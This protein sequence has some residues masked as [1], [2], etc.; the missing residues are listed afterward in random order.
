MGYTYNWN[1]LQDGSNPSYGNDPLHVTDFIGPTEFVVSAG[2]T[3]VLDSYVYASD[4]GT[5]LVPE[6]GTA[7]LLL[8]GAG[9]VCF[10]R[11]RRPSRRNET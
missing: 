10:V 3:V 1:S 7:A 4:L 5:W 6:P 11:F 2:S 9:V 8:F